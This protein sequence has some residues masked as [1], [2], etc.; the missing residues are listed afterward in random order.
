MTSRVITQAIAIHQSRHNFVFLG[1]TVLVSEPA[2]IGG[3]HFVCT[4]ILFVPEIMSTIKGII[5]PL[6]HEIE[7]Q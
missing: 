5:V 4:A 3:G 6:R 2:V 1:T 7:Q